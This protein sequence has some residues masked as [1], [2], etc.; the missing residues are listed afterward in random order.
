MKKTKSCTIRLPIE[1]QKKFTAL[2][3]KQSQKE[4]RIVTF[5]EIII[6]TLEN[7]I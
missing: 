1:L 2:A 6:K 4:K 5:S 7:S 3:I